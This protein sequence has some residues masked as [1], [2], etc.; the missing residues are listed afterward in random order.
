MRSRVTGNLSAIEEV[1]DSSIPTIL[2]ERTVL[3][4]DSNRKLHV[5]WLDAKD[6]NLEIYHRIKDGPTWHPAYRITYNTIKNLAPHVTSDPDGNIHLIYLE[7]LTSDQYKLM[8]QKWSGT[9]LSWSGPSILAAVTVLHSVYGPKVATDR[10]GYIHVIWTDSRH[11]GE[12][13]LYYK[14]FSP[15]VMFPELKLNKTTFLGFAD[16]MEISVVDASQNNNFFVRNE[17]DVRVFSDTDPTGV[18]LTL[19]ETGNNTSTFST[20]TTGNHVQFSKAGSS[21]PGSLPPVIQIY[22]GDKLTV[23]YIDDSPIIA[24]E[25]YG[26]WYE[27]TIPTPTPSYVPIGSA[28]YYILFI[29]FSLICIIYR[30]VFPN[31]G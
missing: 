2:A 29:T 26:H 12:W 30:A 8:Y 27:S 31:V 28:A 9:T 16:Q 21:P 3:T 17:L 24:R 19:T 14:K 22:D 1:T 5:I 20:A 18:E 6:G 15:F 10:F 4:M 7:G 25:V 13:E 23:Q 11:D